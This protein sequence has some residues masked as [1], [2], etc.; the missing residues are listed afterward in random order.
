MLWNSNF[1]MSDEAMKILRVLIDVWLPDFKFGPGRCAIALSRTPR[2]WETVTGNLALIRRWGEDFT[3]RHLVMPNHVECCTYPILDWIAANMP[4][5]PVNIM[6]QYHPDN[7]CDPCGAKYDA[8]HAD[9]A[10]P[11]TREELRS[12]FAYARRLGLKF[13]TISYEKNARALWT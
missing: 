9:I 3:I 5:A 4:E 7:F 8:R 11:P 13:E 10:R 1:F 2:Y 6:D 12:S